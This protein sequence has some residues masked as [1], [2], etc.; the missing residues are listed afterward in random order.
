VLIGS[1]VALTC[2]ILAAAL[3][4]WRHWSKKRQ[5]AAAYHRFGL[6]PEETGGDL[7]APTPRPRSKLL[8]L[9]VLILLNLV[10]FSVLLSRERAV[11]AISTQSPNPSGLSSSASPSP[12]SSA[13]R[14]PAATTTPDTGDNGTSSARKIIQLE[15]PV[16]SAKPFQTIQI[17]GTYR[18][19]PD[20]FVQVQR[21]E[22]SEWQPYPLRWRTDRSGQFTAYV[23]PGPPGRYTLRVIDPESGVK[24]NT[25][26]LVIKG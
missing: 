25:F 2:L 21:R 1:A 18:G 24:S 12:V 17:R 3:V 8:V 5:L 10:V 13:S 22:G 14:P 11:V 7:P 19:G 16:D 26:V 9:A 20:T 6:H 15:E 4:I 23:E